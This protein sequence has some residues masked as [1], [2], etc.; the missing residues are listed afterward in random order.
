MSNQFKTNKV[1]S[2]AQEFIRKM[3]KDTA[4]PKREHSGKEVVANPPPPAPKAPEEGE[5]KSYLARA[6]KLDSVTVTVPMPLHSMLIPPPKTGSKAKVVTNYPVWITCGVDTQVWQ[7]LNVIPKENA[8]DFQQKSIRNMLKTCNNFVATTGTVR[9]WLDRFVKG[10]T[11]EAI[12]FPYPWLTKEPFGN[13]GAD[14]YVSHLM[15]YKIL[16]MDY[17]AIAQDW[18]TEKTYS[19]RARYE[20]TYNYES[21]AGLLYANRKKDDEKTYNVMIETCDFLTKHLAAIG[22]AHNNKYYKGEQSFQ[23]VLQFYNWMVQNRPLWVAAA[24]SPKMEVYER[25]EAW[26]PE[27]GEPFLEL[28]KTRP[29]YV[30]N[31]HWTYLFAPI[32]SALKKVMVPFHKGGTWAIGFSWANGG[33]QKLMKMIED[34]PVDEFR[35]AMYGD[36]TFWVFNIRNKKYLWGPD[37]TQADSHVVRAMGPLMR[38]VCSQAFPNMSNYYK[39]LIE[40]WTIMCFRHPTVVY[41]AHTVFKKNHLSTGINGTTEMDT[42]LSMHLVDEVGKYWM[43]FLEKLEETPNLSDREIREE[44]WKYLGEVQARMKY[45]TLKPATLDLFSWSHVE[46]TS[47]PYFVPV[48]FLGFHLL[49]IGRMVH[50]SGHDMFAAV[51]VQEPLDLVK[52]LVFPRVVGGTALNNL[53]L[54]RMY[55]ICFNGLYMFPPL[56]NAC[57]VKFNLIRKSVGYSSPKEGEPEEIHYEVKPDMFENNASMPV[58]DFAFELKSYPNRQAVFDFMLG[59]APRKWT[60]MLFENLNVNSQPFSSTTDFEEVEP[61]LFNTLNTETMSDFLFHTPIQDIGP[62]KSGQLVAKGLS[63]KQKQ[64]QRERAE[65][66]KPTKIAKE[67]RVW[68]KKGGRQDMETADLLEAKAEMEAE[69]EEQAYQLNDDYENDEKSD[70]SSASEDSDREV[71]LRNRG[72]EEQREDSDDDYYDVDQDVNMDDYEY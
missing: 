5:I 63:A 9:S 44:L 22:T 28:T 30:F 11:Q 26:D 15:E 37:I 40:L 49:I 13:Y 12:K 17:D 60:F 21:R 3:M 47:K 56:Y 6:T 68:K 45:I 31:Y 19:D 7:A 16:C 24:L 25:A 53:S 27:T 52:S 55:Q 29:Y 41:K 46:N 2:E 23:S 43:D 71:P 58:A 62:Q 51:P 57:F 35:V 67:S 4:A 50:Q 59:S 32:T 72:K 65:R 48:K 70:H 54:T 38:S 66:M 34:C 18:L 33:A 36:D 10:M 69:A 42:L 20:I 8:N 14:K 39:N 64:E 61:V 1:S